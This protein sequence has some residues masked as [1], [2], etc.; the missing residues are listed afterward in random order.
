MWWHSVGCVGRRARSPGW[1]ALSGQQ[2]VGQ[3]QLTLACS[4]SP[5]AAA[6]VHFVRVASIY[7]AAVPNRPLTCPRL[8]RFVVSCK[9]QRRLFLGAS[10]AH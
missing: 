5:F 2:P 3:A 7:T 4:A 9:L 10:L 8:V 6:L 1:P